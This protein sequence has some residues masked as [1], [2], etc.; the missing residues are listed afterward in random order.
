M[1]DPLKKPLSILVQDDGPSIVVKERNSQ[2]LLQS[3]N[4]RTQ[5]RLGDIEFFCRQ[6]DMLVIGRGLKIAELGQ[7]HDMCLQLHNIY[8]IL[9]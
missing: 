7:F 1:V 8:L 6:G 2:L 4:H 3:G 9:I 5:G